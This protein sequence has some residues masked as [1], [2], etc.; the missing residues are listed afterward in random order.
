[1]LLAEQLDFFERFAPRPTSARAT[2]SRDF[3]LEAQSA[4]LLR[5]ARATRIADRVRVVWSSRLRTAAGRA[6][7]RSLVITLNPR[8]CEHGEAEIDRTLR[9]EL[10]HLLAQSR[11]G[12]RRIR[13]HGDEWRAACDALG[14]GGESRC[15][16]LPFPVQRRTAR[17]V[18]G[19][20]CC[21]RDFPR[22]R[23]IRRRLA[24]LACCR[25]HN[26]GE[27]DARFTLRLL[28]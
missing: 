26:G 28:R 8:L 10:A 19:C 22:V 3:E 13:P 25:E 15:H 14:I 16:A 18:Y 4:A 17:Y 11:A 5:A 12:R 6:D 27:F 7:S 9:H 2:H 24:C 1:M 21:R 23:R 20:P